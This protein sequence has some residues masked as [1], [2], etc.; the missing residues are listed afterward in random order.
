MQ[1]SRWA[2]LGT[3]ER[4]AVSAAWPKPASHVT[5][6][7]FGT[8]LSS[9]GCGFALSELL[10]GNAFHEAGESWLSA[11]GEVASQLAVT[12]CRW[13]LDSP[14]DNSG[15]LKGIL[16]DVASEAG[17][18]WEIELVTNPDRVLSAT[19]QV[20]CSSDH[21]IVD[22]CQRWFN[23]ARQMIADQV[24]QARVV[25]LGPDERLAAE[26]Q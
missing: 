8:A 10:V 5:G 16:Q 13:W 1:Y 19:D 22:R 9:G 21:A 24:P 12:R 18:P 23:L 26:G 4:C 17:W 15:R 20:V 14:V 7:N 11:S 3:L 25:D 6:E 2:A